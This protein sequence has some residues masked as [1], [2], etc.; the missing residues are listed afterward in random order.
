M[1]VEAKDRLKWAREILL[2]ARNKLAV[3]RDRATHGHAIDM[4]QII[5]MVDAA[6]LVCKEIIGEQ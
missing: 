6:S 3:E 1:Q 5:T 4:I 2:I